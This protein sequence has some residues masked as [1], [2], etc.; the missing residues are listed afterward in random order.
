MSEQSAQDR[1]AELSTATDA[2]ERAWAELDAA[3]AV[4]SAAEH[5]AL[6]AGDIAGSEQRRREATE[7]RQTA[8]A[9]Q[10][11]LAALRT[12]RDELAAQVVAEQQ[13]ARAAEVRAERDA[14]VAEFDALAAAYHN[15]RDAAALAFLQMRHL[16]AVLLDL[17][18]EL[19]GH[20]DQIGGMVRR[21]IA[22]SQSRLGQLLAAE[23]DDHGTQ[24]GPVLGATYARL[25]HDRRART[26]AA[27]TAPWGP[28]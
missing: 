19:D 26:A 21:R 11:R 24:I 4:A 12:A 14:R 3:Y 28:A 15:A 2:A 20:S 8:L 6:V 16:D 18:R 23:T 13:A 1:L 27:A 10:P 9:L 5:D 17:D 25:E 7:H 22:P